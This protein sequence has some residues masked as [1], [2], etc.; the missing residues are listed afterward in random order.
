[1]SG[2]HRAGDH[3]CEAE[4]ER[5]ELFNR[6]GRITSELGLPVD[7]TAS[8]IIEAIRERIDDERE[9]CVGVEVKVEV[10]EGAED[11]TPLEAFEEG[12]LLL[13]TAFRDAIRDLPEKAA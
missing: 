11:W 6:L 12:M 7:C 13:D 1:M 8:R 4:A 2:L 9:R 10:P 3:Y 5:D